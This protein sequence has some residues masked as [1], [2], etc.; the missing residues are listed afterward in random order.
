MKKLIN[1]P[2]KVVHEMLEGMVLAHL[3]LLKRLQGTTVLVRNE[4][5]ARA[6]V[7]LVSG[8]GSGH[9]PSHAGFVGKGM[10]DGAVAGEV[11][12]SPTPDQ[13]FEAIKAVDRGQG[14]LLIIKNY[15]GDIMNFEMAAELAEAEGIS[16]KQVVV[17]D[18]AAVEDST[19]TTGR[20]GIAGTVFVHKI[21]GAL[22]E[23]GASL[24]DV[25]RVASK[26]INN[27]RSM[28]M[29]LS[30]CTVPAAGKPGFEI[31]ENEM[32]I[33]MGIHGEPGI[34]R[35]EMA[36]ADEIAVTLVSH[37]LDDL[38]LA[39][40]DRVAVMI[41]GLGATPLMELYIINKKVAEILNEK[42]IRV[43]DTFVGEYM[44]SLEMAGCSVTL[45]KLDDELTELLEAPAHTVAW[46][47]E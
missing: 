31:G 33:G 21:A 39:S 46:K 5:P 3:N 44:T 2:E 11:F 16:V 26:V 19:Y 25:H 37:I 1:D 38:K 20:R 10:L 27:V 30:P 32:E 6:K 35:A 23:Q 17:N 4:T 7:A 34:Q 47:K 36:S 14:V 24:E 12:T 18:D 29:A 8:G 42:E 28:G 40:G 13:V 45:L 41:N 22:A 9:E 43:H 15:S